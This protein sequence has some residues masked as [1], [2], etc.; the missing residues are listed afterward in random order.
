MALAVTDLRNHLR[1]Q[2]EHR[3]QLLEALATCLN[4]GDLTEARNLIARLGLPAGD[5]AVPSR[6]ST[7]A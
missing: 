5:T 7:D 2:D 1:A 4:A 6:D 3:R